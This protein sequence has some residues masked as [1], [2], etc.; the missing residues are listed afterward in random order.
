MRRLL[1]LLLSV[2]SLLA[3]SATARATAIIG[4]GN[5]TVVT[6]DTAPNL[7]AVD[8]NNPQTLAAGTYTATFFNRQMNFGAGNI[9][10]LLLTSTSPT[11]YVTIALGASQSSAVTQAFTATTF[12]GS[13]TFTLGA[14][15]T[16]Y[17]GIYWAAGAPAMPVGFAAPLGS[18]TFVRFAGAAAPV[19]GNA[20]G[21]GS[22]LTLVRS[23][24]FSISV[25]PVPV[26]EPSTAALL[27]IGI[28]LLGM[29]RRS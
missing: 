4:P 26:P 12:G 24:D 11:S 19:V 25:E 29:R 20:I 17:G 28:T 1:P 27:A 6:Y 10:P 9:Q 16:V 7:I 23:Y 15:T 5:V 18:S 3:F 14:T 8:L 21:G 13:N 22:S 2:L